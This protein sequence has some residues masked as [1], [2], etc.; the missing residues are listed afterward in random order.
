MTYIISAPEGRLHV[1]PWSGSV[2]G[3]DGESYAPDV[4]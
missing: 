3:V 2:S 1:A 4:V